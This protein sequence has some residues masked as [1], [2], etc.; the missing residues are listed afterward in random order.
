VLRADRIV[1]IEAG[2]IVAEGTHAE[3]LA[4]NGLYAELARLQ[5]LD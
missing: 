3:L 4:Q 1:V 2:S 5:F